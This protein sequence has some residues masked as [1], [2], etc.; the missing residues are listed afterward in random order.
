MDRRLGHARFDELDPSAIHDLVRVGRR[1]GD[2][3][4]EVIGDAHAQRVA[5]RY[6][7]RETDRD[8]SRPT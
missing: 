3:P 8:P 4:A 2:R 6:V 5:A 1:D 7:E